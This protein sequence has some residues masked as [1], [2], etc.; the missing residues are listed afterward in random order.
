MS[1]RDDAVFEQD[2]DPA[3]DPVPSAREGALILIVFVGLNGLACA[4][5][6]FYLEGQS[7]M[8]LGI[9]TAVLG[10]MGLRFGQLGWLANLASLWAMRV[11]MRSYSIQ[12]AVFSLVAL[13]LAAHTLTLMGAEIQV[14]W[15]PLDY[16]RLIGLGPGF[17]IWLAGLATPL[18]VWL[19]R[20][21]SLRGGR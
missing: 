14:G 6:A 12:A 16:V 7:T 2:E 10:P 1:A 19:V 20:R 18:T 5:P 9:E 4:S 13:A 17:F 3:P 8:W 21:M 11:V 15:G